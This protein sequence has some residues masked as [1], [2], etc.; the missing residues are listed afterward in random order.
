MGIVRV[1]K[2]RPSSNLILSAQLIKAVYDKCFSLCKAKRAL[3]STEKGV[4]EQNLVKGEGKAG[5]V[6]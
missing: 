3:N 6:K 1:L 4:I 2:S 5:K